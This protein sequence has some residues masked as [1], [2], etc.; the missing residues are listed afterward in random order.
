M[1]PRVERSLGVPHPG[2]G[3]VIVEPEMLD[4]MSVRGSVRTAVNGVSVEAMDDAIRQSR[5]RR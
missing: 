2:N 5:G 4:L 1:V 3:T